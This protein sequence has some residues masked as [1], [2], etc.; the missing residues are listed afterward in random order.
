MTTL[1]QITTRAALGVAALLLA[2]PAAAYAAETPAPDTTTQQVSGTAP[3]NGSATSKKSNVYANVCGVWA[4]RV[5]KEFNKQGGATTAAGSATGTT[6]VADAPRT[7][8]AFYKNY[9]C[10]ALISGI[11]ADGENVVCINSDAQVIRGEDKLPKA[12]SGTLLDS[13]AAVLTPTGMAGFEAILAWIYNILWGLSL[14]I[15]VA[16]IVISGLQY[17]LSATGMADDGAAKDRIK[18][19]IAGIVLMSLA[20]TIM[21]FINPLFFN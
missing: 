3:T 10:T 13:C 16:V 9:M 5:N 14:V 1:K 2:M 12:V 20:G 4:T 21:K 11:P 7:E 15:G 8:D 18:Y 6:P 19:A 17:S